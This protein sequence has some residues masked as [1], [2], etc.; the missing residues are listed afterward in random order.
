MGSTFRRGVRTTDF[1][2]G[3]EG[4]TEGEYWIEQ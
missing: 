1:K 2:G 4:L 3:G